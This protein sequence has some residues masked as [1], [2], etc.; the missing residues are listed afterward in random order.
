MKRLLSALGINSVLEVLPIM[1]LAALIYWLVR[2]A[3]QK[4][5]FGQ[6]FKSIR[7][8]FRANEA[9]RLLLVCWSVVVICMTLTPTGFWGK[10]WDIILFQQ[11]SMTPIKF[12]KWRFVS[13]WWTHF[14]KYSGH[15]LS[16]VAL[17]GEV[18]NTVENIIFFVPIGLGLSFLWKKKSFVKIILLGA[19]RSFLVEFIQA[20]IGRDGNIDDFLCNTLGTVLGYLLYLLI[21]RVFPNF[22]EKAS[23]SANDVWEKTRGTSKNNPN[24]DPSA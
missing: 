17:L 7:R 8:K 4:K 5:L 21:K 6:D 24:T 12:E 1:L 14:I 9:I 2:R 3:K 18:I 13:V 11:G 20:F 16:G 22:T 23:L 19:S 15:Y 10:L